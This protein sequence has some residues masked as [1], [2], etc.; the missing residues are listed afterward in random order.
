VASCPACREELPGEFPFCPFCAASLT[1]LPAAPVRE[2]RKVVSVL[3]CDLVGFTAA[4]ER[5]DPEDVRAR[6]RPYHERL[7]VEIERF[8]G[9]VEKFVGDAVM[10]VFGAPVSHEDD[11][12]RA[13]RAGLRILDAIVELNDT[14]RDLRLQVR[15]GVNTGEAVVSL[16]ARPERGEGIVAGDVVNTAARIQAAAP[17]NGVAVSEETYRQTERLFVYERL[18]PAEMKGKSEPVGLHRAVEARSRFGSDLIRA[19]TSPFVG[20]EVERSLLQGL[21]ERCT[22]DSQTQLVT[23]VGEPGVGKSRLCAELFRYIDEHPEI[24][25]WRQG[26]CLPY[27]DG[28]TFWALGEI[29]KAHAGVY[30]SDSPQVAAQKL[31]VVLPEVEELAWMRGRLL[32]LLGIDSGQPASRE[33]SFTA[34]RRFIEAIAADG[35]LVLVWE[36]L[37]WADPSLLD[38]VAYLAEWAEGVPLLLLC[39][40]R[41]ELYEKHL[42]WGSSTRNETRINLS[43]LSDA[44]T[45]QLV[46]ALMAKTVTG[47]VEQ[48][49]LERSGGNPLYAEE[50]VRLIADRGLDDGNGEMAFPDSVQALIAA[51]LDTLTVER[52]GLL[53]DASVV[54]KLFWAGAVAEM[55]G[56][57]LPEVELAL[58]ELSRKELVRPARTS[59][60]EGETEY[61]FWHALV[62]DVAY[63]QIPRASRSRR[64]RA[65]AAW[66]ERKAGERVEDLAEVLSHHYLA[67]LELATATDD[68]EQTAQLAAPARRYLALAGERALPLDVASAEASLAKALDLTPTDHPERAHLLERWAQAAQQQG[69]PQEAR[70]AL[71]EAIALYRERMESVAAGRALCQLLSVLSSLGDP[72]R[73]ETIAEAIALLEAEQPGPELVT[74]YGELAGVHAILFSAFPEA[75][76]AGERAVELAAELRLPEPTRALG[77]LGLARACLGD[78]QGLN[79]MRR[80]L[81]LSIE[82]GRARDAAVIY[83]NLA[84]TLGLYEGPQA[85]LATC[86][87]GL[88]FCERRGIAEFA[89]ATAI[90]S[91]TFLAACGRSEQA[92]VEAEPLAARA[93]AVGA[94]TSIWARSL[95]VQ[96]LTERGDA[97]QSV[98]DAERLAATARETAEP[99]QIALGFAAA[100]H[101]LLAQGEHEQAQAL[102]CELEQTAGT[103]ADVYYTANLPGLVRCA[104]ALQDQ[105]LAVR[106][107]EGIE[108]RTPLAEYALCAS[109]AALTEAARNPTEAAALYAGA[110]ERWAEFGHVPERAYALLGEGRCLLTLGTPHANEP[111]QEARE[112]FKQMG[113]KPA[114]AE[115]DTLLEQ[116]TAAA[117]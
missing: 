20:R 3:F 56:R 101:L 71:E 111:L 58:H 44:E 25:R 36:D 35:P 94:T 60:M 19:Q 80:A 103:R 26:R 86:H 116:T 70:A 85:A 73:E 37:H 97:A 43:P 102:L 14:G 66:I 53:Q 46:S 95:Q 13:V 55:G 90:L 23:L 40:A 74:A 107:A 87:E 83:N 4:S 72:R 33:E 41:P 92:L 52:K 106:L 42:G 51:R 50:F 110:A 99:Q 68:R 24:I 108:P 28:I 10:A 65:A 98:A 49:I 115:T 112:L 88:D 22:R 7:R 27:G 105:E 6:L 47:E 12:E 84:E 117:S 11:P 64:H 17:V 89:L 109:R 34:W 76:A 82:R 61:A 81:A 91:L 93:E 57:D 69:R 104:L 32:P 18:E 113:Y 96:V 48:A 54:G 29:V 1:E 62:R 77:F 31:E 21:F 78:R 100:A 9:T 63:N 45:G 15:V 79:D 67:A 30:E 2:E 5:V 8:G 59:S 39:T 75:I 16:E 38:F 114:L